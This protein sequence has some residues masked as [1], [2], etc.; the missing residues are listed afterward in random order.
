MVKDR[1]DGISWERYNESDV[2]NPIYLPDGL[3]PEQLQFWLKEA[4][5]QR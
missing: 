4:Q 5:S 2:S 1:L 3:S